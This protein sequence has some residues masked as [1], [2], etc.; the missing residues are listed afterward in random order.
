MPKTQTKKSY[1]IDDHHT[2]ELK[3]KQMQALHY[4][5]KVLYGMKAL[6]DVIHINV[7]LNKNEDDDD[8][9]GYKYDDWN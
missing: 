5:N 4:A 6:D 3:K 9:E 7:T 8:D 2:E 1:L